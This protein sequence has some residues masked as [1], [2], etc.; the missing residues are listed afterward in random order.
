[1]FELGA[2]AGTVASDGFEVRTPVT[3]ADEDA[4]RLVVELRVA[5]SRPLEFLTVRL[6]RTSTGRLSL[7]AQP[8]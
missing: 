2:F 4:G 7:E 5:P 1:M 3:A 6:V 8:A